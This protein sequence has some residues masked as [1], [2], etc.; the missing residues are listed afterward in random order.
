MVDDRE[1]ANLLGETPATPDAGFRFDVFA[2]VTE[3]R[4]RRE[5]F[6]RAMLRVAACTGV[7]LA[8]LVA[9][10]AGLTA[11][12]LTPILSAAGA[13]AAAGVAYTVLRSP[14]A[15]LARIGLAR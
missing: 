1:L 15:A 12:S 6:G 10:A 13:L 5:A 14:R 2:R 4:R 11:E 7:G 9:Q 3:R 8:V